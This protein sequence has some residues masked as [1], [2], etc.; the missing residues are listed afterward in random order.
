MQI[1]DVII[2]LSDSATA[3][4][5][6]PRRNVTPAEVQVLR[7]IKGDNTVFFNGNVRNVNRSAQAEANR[8]VAAHGGAFYKVFAIGSAALPQTFAEVGLNTSKI[9]ETDPYVPAPDETPLLETFDEDGEPTEE[10]VVAANP[11]VVKKPSRKKA[12]RPVED[13]GISK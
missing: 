11:V 12:A 9:I 2:R 13:F 6:T 10:I 1:C 8:L 3:T 7:H 4:T 5:N